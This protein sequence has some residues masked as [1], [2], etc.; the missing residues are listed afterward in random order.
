MRAVGESR[1][2]VGIF[3]S[4]SDK[5]FRGEPFRAS[6]N[7]CYGEIMEEGV[8]VSRFSVEFFLCHS[9][10]KIRTGTLQCFRESP[11]SKNFM[12]RKGT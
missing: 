7:I 2:S 9:P 6:E 12:Q 10:E 8:G 5:K 1:F 3:K 4:L 11:V